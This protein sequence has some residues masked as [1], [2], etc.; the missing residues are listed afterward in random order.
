MF[1][2]VQCWG[3]DGEVDV[4]AQDSKDFLNLSSYNSFLSVVFPSALDYKNF[5]LQNDPSYSREN[6]VCPLLVKFKVRMHFQNFLLGNESQEGFLPVT[7][8]LSLYLGVGRG[9]HRA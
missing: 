3:G 7:P 8:I 1:S 5:T 9:H 4:I 2:P 6:S